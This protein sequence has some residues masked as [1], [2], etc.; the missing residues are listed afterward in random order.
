[1]KVLVVKTS[2]M[3]DLVHAQPI[4]ADMRRHHPEVRVDWVCEAPF[5]PIPALNAG[6][7]QVI[8][9]RWRSWRRRLTDPQTRQAIGEFVNR[10]RSQRYDWVIDCQGLIKSA[11][12]TRLARGARRAG[13]AWSSA[14]E[15]L[16]SLGYDRRAQVPWSLHVVERNRAVAA[17]ALGYAVEG[18]ARFGLRAPAL[19]AHWVPPRG[20][21]A[22]LITG[23]SRPGKLWTA[24]GWLSVAG[25][26]LDRSLDLV[27]L[28]GDAAEHERACALAASAGAPWEDAGVRNGAPG[29]THDGSWDGAAPRSVVPPF[30]SVADA[31]SLL[32]GAAVVV[33]LDTG[34]THLAGA[35]G[36]PTVAVFCDF[37]AT[38]CAVSGDGPCAS[39]G[40]VGQQPDSAEIREGVARVLAAAAPPAD[41][42]SRTTPIPAR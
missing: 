3:G 9:M 27:W 14:R 20:A 37:D 42:Q 33:G 21:Y 32:D 1:L 26:L 18:P 10:L 12:L 35:L 17:A 7:A 31:A 11:V 40:G 39:F 24:A 36:R 34:F 19:L 16:A 2:S 13:F 30:L 28:W 29:A 6:V 22:V 41:A 38:Q 5:A 4:V 23:A 25:D 15:P 8:P